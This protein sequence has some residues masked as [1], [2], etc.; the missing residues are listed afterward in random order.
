MADP[1]YVDDDFAAL[2]RRK[3][4]RE[5]P[6]LTL[7]FGDAVEVLDTSDAGWTKVRALTH[8]DGTAEGFVKGRPPL[9]DAGI[10]KF[11]MV[12]VQQGDGLV[13]ETPGGEIMLIDGGDN[14]LF[15][16]HVAARFRH[17]APSAENPLDVAAILVTHGDA[18]HFDGLNVIRRSETDRD[19]A[20]EPRKRLHIHPRRLYHNGL[21]K[22][23]GSVAERDIFGR[24]VERDG[25]TLIVDLYDDPREA[26][27]ELRNRPFSTWC[28]SLDHWQTRGA[29]DCRRVAFGMPAEEAFDFLAA[30]GIGVEIQGPFPR[31]VVDGGRRRPALPF[32]HRPKKSAEMHLETPADPG[33]GLSASHTINGHSIALRLTYGNVRFS[34]TGDLNRESMALMRDHLDLA[35]LE[36]EIVKA[37]HHGSHDFDFAALAAMKPVVGI[38]SSGD[39]SVR[40]EHVHP[41][42]TL[43]SALGKV[44]RGDTGVVFCTELAAF[45]A[46]EEESHSREALERFFKA[47]RDQTF[48]GAEL[49]KLFRGKPKRGAET[50][51]WFFG[52]RRTNFG[53]VHVRTDGERVLAFTHSGKQGLNEAYSFRV[54][55]AGGK[56]KVAFDREVTTR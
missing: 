44:M 13:L 26:P 37:P 23:P 8:F 5:K 35:D 24:T 25:D 54:T 56:R 48:T 52:F 27:P 47:R 40:K 38:V 7:A 46:V 3:N 55:M 21:V 31:T 20:G 42:A 50:P 41:R 9:R 4:G 11:S 18:D 17:R 30:E 22:A 39:E 51:E 14:Q 49:A 15:A 53:I 29:I 1:R 45:F 43:M 16:R 32:L 10:L 2:R 28:D 12:D 36:A 6:F 33:G 34:L 19:L